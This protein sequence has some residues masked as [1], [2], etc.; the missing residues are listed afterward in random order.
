[1]GVFNGQDKIT[2]LV[3]DLESY[4]LDESAEND[5]SYCFKDWEFRL[6]EIDFKIL[7]M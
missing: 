4:L 2:P 7:R 5:I 6:F 1:M 3:K